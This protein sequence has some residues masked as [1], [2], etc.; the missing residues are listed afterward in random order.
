MVA[1]WHTPR[2]SKPR[3]DRTGMAV[4]SKLVELFP[5]WRNDGTW[6]RIHSRLREAVQVSQGA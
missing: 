5:H 2:L 6:K 1:R 3:S 4:A